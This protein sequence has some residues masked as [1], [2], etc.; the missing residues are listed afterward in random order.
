MVDRRIL[1]LPPVEGS[2]APVAIHSAS[3]LDCERRGFKPD[4]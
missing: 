1:M 4:Y 3:Q 2:G